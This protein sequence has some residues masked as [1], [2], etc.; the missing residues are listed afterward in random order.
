MTRRLQ[1]RHLRIDFYEHDLVGEM[2]GKHG[3]V[4][5]AGAEHNAR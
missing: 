5:L 4:H 3:D 2:N 1:P